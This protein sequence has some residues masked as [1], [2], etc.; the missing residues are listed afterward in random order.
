MTKEVLHEIYEM[1]Q[2]ELREYILCILRE[3]NIPYQLVDGNIFSF[4]FKDKVAFVSHLDTVAKSDEEYHKQVFECNG[5]LFKRNAILGADD[6]AGVNI[7]LNHIE[8]I[9][10]ILTRDEEVGRLGANVLAKDQ[11]FI[12][13]L[14]EYN[15]CGF[16]EMD[17]R[18][19][20]DIIGAR[21]GYCRQ[22]FHDA[23]HNVLTDRTDE[24]GVCTD[25]DS[26]LELRPGVNLSC[27]Y[28]NAHSSDEFLD[29]ETWLNLNNKIPELNEI[30]GSFSLPEQ[31]KYSFSYTSKSRVYK[32]AY[33][34]TYLSDYVYEEYDDIGYN[35]ESNLIKTYGKFNQRT[36]VPV[37]NDYYYTMK[38]Y[39]SG[40]EN[41]I[42]PLKYIPYVSLSSI[43]NLQKNSTNYLVCNKCG[44]SINRNEKYHV[45]DGEFYHD[46]CITNEEKEIINLFAEDI[47][48]DYKT[49]YSLNYLE[50]M[51]NRKDC[52]EEVKGA[53]AL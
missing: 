37:Q 1:N 45:I 24:T 50:V 53:L 20:H 44:C 29:I 22:D 7:I 15:I 17:R 48:K 31:K 39:K 28:H 23:V 18:N 10:F 8:N 19:N 52:D 43:C 40:E 36:L 27:G 42:N 14:N 12:S 25:I 5:I 35:F 4:R 51:T 9:N 11:T 38:L 46:K 21:H 33:G 3:K 49:E 13:I 32:S 34:S 6:R 47:L 16:I 41:G 26:W 2:E 30:S